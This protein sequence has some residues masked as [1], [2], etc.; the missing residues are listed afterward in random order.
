M[1]AINRYDVRT[2]LSTIPPSLPV[3]VLHGSE[4]KSVY[5]SEA[6]E[7]LKGIKHAQMAKLP[8]DDYGHFFYDYFDT[9]TWTGVL[10]SFLDAPA[11]KL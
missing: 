3:L 1:R 6:D 8:A 10:E 2:R 7:L 9:A 5:V 4:D 11:A